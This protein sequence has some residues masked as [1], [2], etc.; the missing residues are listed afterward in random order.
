MIAQAMR[1]VLFAKATAATRRCFR[2]RRGCQPRIGLP[3]LEHSN[4]A[5]AP[6]TSKT[7][8]KVD[9]ALA[10]PAEAGLAAGRG[11]ARHEASQAA[12]ARPLRN[13]LGSGTS[14]RG[15]WQ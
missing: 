7:P 15:R 9:A 8:D 3:A 4:T 6:L 1:A 12:N 14:L 10:D 5:R 11:R 2:V 13:A